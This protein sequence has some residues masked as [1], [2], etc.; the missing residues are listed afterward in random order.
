MHAFTSTPISSSRT[1]LLCLISCCHD[2]SVS[3]AA[4]TRCSQSI[5][6]LQWLYLRYRALVNFPVPL[7]WCEHQSPPPEHLQLVFARRRRSHL[8]NLP[9]Q[10]CHCFIFFAGC[11]GR[12]AH[13][14]SA[15]RIMKDCHRT[16]KSL[17]RGVM[18]LE[19][20][21]GCCL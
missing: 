18:E 14:E 20:K 3:H 17:P 8:R 2:F 15:P 4:I 11:K 10:G 13:L 12:S 5:G 1:F 7:A 6:A 19:G 21:N 16:A 9:W